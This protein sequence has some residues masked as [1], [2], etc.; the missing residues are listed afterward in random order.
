MKKIFIFLLTTIMLSCAGCH[1]AQSNT[2]KVEF[3]QDEK[4]VKTYNLE[5]EHFILRCLMFQL[6]SNQRILL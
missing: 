2:C 6:Q 5:K 4:I 1:S 3:V